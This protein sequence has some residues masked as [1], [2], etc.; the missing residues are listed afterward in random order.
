MFQLGSQPPLHTFITHYTPQTELL[1]MARSDWWDACL[2]QCKPWWHHPACS[3]GCCL[4]V[5]A[6]ACGLHQHSAIDTHQHSTVLCL[7]VGQPRASS[8]ATAPPQTASA[9]A[10]SS[11]SKEP[12]SGFTD[13]VMPPE[14]TGGAASASQQAC[15]EGDQGA[16]EG[17]ARQ[18]AAE[19]E[20]TMPGGTATGGLRAEPSK[21]HSVNVD[22]KQR[23]LDWSAAA[24]K[25]RK[26]RGSSQAT[27]CVADQLQ[28]STK[29]L[30][31][32]KRQRK[33]KVS[34]S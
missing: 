31:N 20:A 5:L 26:A 28:Q 7:F 27:S 23:Q 3:H 2:V 25:K 6:V 21:S 19:P 15:D 33:L 17:N 24:G 32:L 16:V 4:D 22:A 12:G 1:C 11:N 9:S 18:D 34:S 13:V 10:I 8:Q 14:S 30:P 29:P